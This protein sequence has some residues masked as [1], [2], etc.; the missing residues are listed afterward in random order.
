MTVNVNSELSVFPVLRTRRIIVGN[1]KVKVEALISSQENT[2]SSSWLG[3]SDFSKYVKFYFILLSDNLANL[4]SSM[5]DAE[6][7]LLSVSNTNFGLTPDINWESNIPSNMLSEVSLL[8]VLQDNYNTSTPISDLDVGST[9]DIY[10]EA[11]INTEELDFNSSSKWHLISFS[12]IDLKEIV[13]DYNLSPS[14]FVSLGGNMVYDLLLQKNDAGKLI[15]PTELEAFFTEIEIQE[16]DSFNNPISSLKQVPYYGPYHYHGESNPG[17]N[18]YIGW[19]A[20]HADGEMGAK[21]IRRMVNYNKVIAKNFLNTE[22]F[23][24][25][26]NGYV[27]Y[28]FS[29]SQNLVSADSTTGDLLLQNLNSITN[30]LNEIENSSQR[31][32]KIKNLSLASFKKKV[33]NLF[34]S[35]QISYIDVR[36]QEIAPDGTSTRNHHGSIFFIKYLDLL[37]S[38]S[39]LGWMLN[40]HRTS[41]SQY[42]KKILLEILSDTRFVNFSIS[43]RRLTNSTVGNTKVTASDYEKYDNNEIPKKLISTLQHQGSSFLKDAENIDAS[44]SELFFD[45]PEETNL[46][47]RSFLLKDYDMF[48]NINYGNYT[49]IID[50]SVKDGI[51]E[52]AKIKLK[53]LASDM[54]RFSEFVVFSRIPARITT[55]L[56]QDEYLSNNSSNTLGCFNYLSNEFTDYFKQQ[57]ITNYSLV[58][59]TAILS[60]IELYIFLN[61]KLKDSEVVELQR[62]L[63][64]SLR[65]N[66]PSCTPESIEEFVTASKRLMKAVKNL[67][68]IDDSQTL[69]RA[70]IMKAKPNLKSIKDSQMSLINIK[71]DTRL[72]VRAISRADIL[73]EPGSITPQITDLNLPSI[74]DTITRFHTDSTVVLPG[75]FFTMTS[76]SPSGEL[77]GFTEIITDEQFYSLPEKNK[78]TYSALLINNRHLDSP[79]T[80]PGEFSI[81]SGLSAGRPSTPRIL[82]F[83]SFNRMGN[84][85][86]SLGSAKLN[87]NFSKVFAN[88]ITETKLSNLATAQNSSYIS[89]ELQDVLC[90]IA[91]FAK[92]K[93]EYIDSVTDLYKDITFIKEALGNLYDELNS[94]TIFMQ[95]FATTK[96]QKFEESRARSNQDLVL[97]E[98][99]NVKPEEI[100]V[101]NYLF[102]SKALTIKEIIPNTSKI[103]A[104]NADMNFGSNKLIKYESVAHADDGLILVNNVII[105]GNN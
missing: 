17:P 25:G 74:R 35:N 6:T 71:A 27:D 76:E 94:A 90:N 18:G 64:E 73:Y 34:D 61:P 16:K 93:E 47:Y 69:D 91:N 20:G 29:T 80:L 5:Q 14:T 70:E 12:H 75:R 19:M 97:S 31:Q 39:P 105:G 85:L 43:R 58:I 38:N 45:F 89:K 13:Q 49:Y 100:N 9:N 26:Y 28:N 48:N 65:P 4:A 96:L 22:G 7:R 77:R 103:P 66:S 32:E 99:N 46:N 23:N 1:D 56:F 30:F 8:E 101:Q 82:K 62:I 33:S 68:S 81:S 87:V 10:F 42:S 83:D 53:K 24:S 59:S 50:M 2:S 57:A 79:R 95:S 21:L 52:L 11:E 3:S 37:E 102:E 40:S 60:F 44:I 86:Q 36:E 84:M 67:I 98:N 63:E 78:L 41:E 54:E 55:N 92:T 51:K 72:S 88:S 104:N 15:T